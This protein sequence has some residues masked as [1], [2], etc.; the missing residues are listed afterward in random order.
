MIGSS[1][2][3]LGWLLA[4]QL[5]CKKMAETGKSK[6]SCRLLALPLAEPEYALWPAVHACHAMLGSPPPS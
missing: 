4:A 6:G 1:Q 3:I 5:D 2:E